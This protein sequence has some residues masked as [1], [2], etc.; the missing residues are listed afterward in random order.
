VRKGWQTAEYGAADLARWPGEN[1]VGIR[2]G[3]QA[4]GMAL[5]VFD[6]DEEAGR[7]FPAW[8]AAVE[9]SLARPLVIVTSGRGYH[10]Y[11]Y[12][13][14]EEGSRL[15]AGRYET[16][17]GRRRLR[18]FVE[19]LGR[20]RQIVSAGSRHP[21]G[22]RYCFLDGGYNAIPIVSE[23][24][25]EALLAA[26]RAID[27]RPASQASPARRRPVRQL[28]G[29]VRD[30]LAY[31]RRFI[32]SEE[33]LEPNGDIR[34]LGQGGLLVTPDGRGWY[35]FGDERGGGLAELVAW[36]QGA[37]GHA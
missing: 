27:E 3:R 12:V 2:C 31:A 1:N 4:N 5:A 10:A 8:R 30:C 11:F 21:S 32:G 6:F 34:F 20:G 13:P 14:R 29:D 15:L 7:V 28:P 33:R 18:K 36:H 35:S 24:G 23:A 9:G 26:S 16:E 22:R 37:V 25:Y 17:N 19:L